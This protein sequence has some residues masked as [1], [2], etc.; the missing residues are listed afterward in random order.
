MA[1]S[2]NGFQ[3]FEDIERAVFAA[4]GWRGA[5]PILERV[6]LEPAQRARF[7]GQFLD[8]PAPA[9]I[10]EQGG[11]LVLRAPFGTPAELVPI[12]PDRV[13]QR[14]RG[15][16]RPAIGRFEENHREISHGWIWN[17]DC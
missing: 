11:R 8:G 17:T 9:V 10:T 7:I 4:Y 12:A 13:V 6:A 15:R 14:D 1:N 2:D 16:Q 5:D 3:I